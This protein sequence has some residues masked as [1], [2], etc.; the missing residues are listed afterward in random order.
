MEDVDAD[1][2]DSFYD[3]HA[4]GKSNPFKGKAK[5]ITKEAW[6]RLRAYIL[7]IQGFPSPSLQRSICEVQIQA[8]VDADSRLGS[9]YVNLK[10]RFREIMF[11]Y[12]SDLLY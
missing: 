7:V 4:S 10:P 11:E 9:F 12:V 3:A 8:T 5:E 6:K 1:D 2:E